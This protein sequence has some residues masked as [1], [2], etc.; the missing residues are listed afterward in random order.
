MQN[1]KPILFRQLDKFDCDIIL[2]MGQY[3][4]ETILGEK[5]TKL[6]DFVGKEYLINF[7]NTTKLV[8]PIYH[9]S[10]ANP[11]CFKGNVPIFEKIKQILKGERNVKII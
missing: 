4:T 11:L 1:C 10:P 3:P 8:V 5:I 7:G 9:T 2:P 6:K